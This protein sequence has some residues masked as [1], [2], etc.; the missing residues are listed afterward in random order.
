VSDIL[1][2]ILEL[3]RRLPEP[4]P[5][6]RVEVGQAVLDWLKATA[7]HEGPAPE[8]AWR[9]IGW[10]PPPPGGSLFGVPIVLNENLEAGAWQV[11]DHKGNVMREGTL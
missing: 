5:V 6:A 2:Q 9:P 11:I 10:T 4:P 3:A 1:A 8:D 7:Q